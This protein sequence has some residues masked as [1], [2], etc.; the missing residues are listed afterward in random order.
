M[1]GRDHRDFPIPIEFRVSR[2]ASTGQWNYT[3]LAGAI[4]KGM[5]QYDHVLPQVIKNHLLCLFSQFNTGMILIVQFNRFKN[6]ALSLP[7][8][9][10]R[11]VCEYFDA[12]VS[13]FNCLKFMFYLGFFDSSWVPSYSGFLF[14]RPNR[15][16]CCF[17]E[18][19]VGVVYSRTINCSRVSYDAAMGVVNLA[20]AGTRKVVWLG[21]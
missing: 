20:P 6:V 13:A 9:F 11:S 16:K 21:F 5:F 19:F 1:N 3:Q 17:V 4:L 10:S 7:S 14:S 15:G 8:L 18:S 12:D 2:D